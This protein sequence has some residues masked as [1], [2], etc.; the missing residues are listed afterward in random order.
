MTPCAKIFRAMRISPSA[1]AEVESAFKLYCRAVE[2]SD[3]TLSSQSTY[4]D[5][6]RAFI[7]WLKNDF[8]PGSRIAPYSPKKKT[9]R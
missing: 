1:L 9:P 6:V 4:E 8:E 5:H 7:R 3:L 2:E